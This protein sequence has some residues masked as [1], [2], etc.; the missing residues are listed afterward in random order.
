MRLRSWFI[1]A[2]VFSCLPGCGQTSPTAPTPPQ[3]S[4]YLVT[5]TV[6]EMVEGISRPVANQFLSFWVQ[7][8]EGLPPG[9]TMR[10]STQYTHTGDG[11]R[12]STQVP[13]R[14]TVS[15][16]AVWGKR[17][18]CVASAVVVRD[19]VI[20]VEVFQGSSDA[21]AV[22]RGSVVTGF[23]YE[24]TPEGRKPLRGAAAWLDA[25]SD[26]WVASTETDASG[27]F[28]FCGVDGSF[29]MDVDAQGYQPYVHSV[30]L[31]GSGH[32]SF[33]FEFSR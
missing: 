18:P 8:T 22:S 30:F 24:S 25:G 13:S 14:S 4:S 33:E 20:D 26:I 28:Y 2:S 7:E 16:S 6:R 12:Y 29:R 10:G 3:A 23:V 27:R 5:G 19:T 11:G 32:R 15:V 21:P 9:I 17:Q 31:Y 1:A